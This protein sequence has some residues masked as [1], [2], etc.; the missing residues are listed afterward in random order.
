MTQ[1]PAMRVSPAVPARDADETVA[2]VIRL[3][4]VAPHARSRVASYVAL[5][6]PR[7][8]ELLL[9]TTLPSMILA[10][11]GL[12]KWWVVLAT[13]V[14]G[15]LAAGSANALNCYVDRDIDAVMRRTTHRP[16]ARHDVSPR[17]ALV[18][19]LVLAVVA[20][21]LMGSVTNWLAA[22]L[23]AAAIVFYVVVYTMLLKR[24]TAQ[25]IVWGGAAGCMPALIGWAAVTGSLAWP[26]VVLFGVIFFWTPPHFWALAIRYRDDYARANV[27]MLPVVAAPTRVAR[28]IVIYAWLTVA[29][30]LALWPLATGWVYGAL[31]LLAGAALIVGAHRLLARTKHGANAKAAMQLF[32]LSN[33]YLAFVFVAVAVDTFVR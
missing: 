9:V 1:S 3:R 19:G 27:P 20:V 16:L 31:A 22:E 5:T 29:T 32:H 10:A 2:P 4:P 7:I 30:S 25:N 23:T 18:F 28:E 13:M 26:A 12:P 17:G 8:I 24:R 15:T 21:A 11:G 33:S 14:G 6:K